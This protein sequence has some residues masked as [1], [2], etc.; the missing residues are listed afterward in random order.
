[1]GATHALT[2]AFNRPASTDKVADALWDFF[3]LLDRHILKRD[4]HLEPSSR[5]TDYVAFHEHLESNAHIHAV[6]RVTPERCARVE[7]LLGDKR[8]WLWSKIAP[9][10]THVLKPIDEVGGWAAY[11]TKSFTQNSEPYFRT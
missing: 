11:M 1:M 7:Y 6:I 5:R 3:G 10:G 9:A 4:F 2:L 8:S